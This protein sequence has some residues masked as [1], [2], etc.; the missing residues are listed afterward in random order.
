MYGDPTA[1]QPVSNREDLYQTVAIFDD[2][3][4]VGVNLTGIVALQNPN[5]FTG[6]NW[7]VSDGAIITASVTQFT[8][9]GLPYTGQLSALAIIIGHNLGILAGDPILIAD[10]AGNATIAGYVTSYVPS[11][12]ALVVQIGVTFQFEIRSRMRHH[13]DGDY[14]PWWD[15]GG[16][17]PGGVAPL[18]SAALGTGLSVVDIGVLLIQIPETRMRQLRHRSY[19]AALTVTDSVSTRQVFIADLPILYGGVTN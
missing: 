14:S 17:S 3:L 18:I 6:N 13:I 10:V 4:N 16:G 15:W 19:L 8:V 2:D 12:G 7:T 5:G 9:P 1:F 11:T